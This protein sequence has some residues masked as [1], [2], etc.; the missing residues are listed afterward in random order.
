MSSQCCLKGIKTSFSP[1]T[2]TFQES[3][4]V[5]RGHIVK[6]MAKLVSLVS[7]FCLCHIT[8]VLALIA[9]FLYWFFAAFSSVPNSDLSKRVSAA[10]QSCDDEV[11]LFCAEV[12]DLTMQKYYFKK[13]LQR[14]ERDGTKTKKDDG[15]SSSKSNFT[16]STRKNKS[17]VKKQQ[18]KVALTKEVDIVSLLN[19][20]ENVEIEMIDLTHFSDSAVIRRVVS[21]D[22]E[23][24]NNFAPIPRRSKGHYQASLVDID[25]EDIWKMWMSCDAKSK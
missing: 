12:S 19:E 8:L 16:E 10:W 17:G 22:I 21:K 1:M 11:K 20:E 24:T 13:F 15:Y 25:D 14:Q 9:L 3:L 4:R 5:R 23:S 7:N 2:G 18:M 6:A